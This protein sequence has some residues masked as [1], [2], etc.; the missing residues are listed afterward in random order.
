MENPKYYCACCVQEL[1]LEN[2]IQ[3]A[4][5]TYYDHECYRCYKQK[6][7]C[8]K[9]NIINVVINNRDYLNDYVCVTCIRNLKLTPFFHIFNL[10]NSE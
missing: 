4:K 9:L 8:Y 10:V 3:R 5:H 7:Y 6:R 1:S 2:L